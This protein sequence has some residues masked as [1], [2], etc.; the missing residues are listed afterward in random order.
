MANKQDFTQEEWNKF[1]ESI[2]V[3]GMA[4]SA[5]DPNGLWGTIREAFAS[6]S[7]ITASK[8]ESGSNELI[9]AVVADFETTQGCSAIQESLRKRVAGCTPAEVVQRSLDELR[10]TSIILEAKA[11]SDAPAF[12]AWLRSISQKVAEASKALRS[13]KIHFGSK[14]TRTG[15]KRPLN[16][17]CTASGRGEPSSS[18]PGLASDGGTILPFA[19]RRARALRLAGDEPRVLF[20]MLHRETRYSPF[21]S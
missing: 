18:C 6:R 19:P 4:V 9:K 20:R 3:A 5:A 7:A 17:S 21:A 11:S 8:R 10:E 2:V 14:A 1:L 16:R 15:A 12:K 13:A